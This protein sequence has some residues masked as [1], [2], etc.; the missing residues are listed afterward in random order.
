MPKVFETLVADNYDAAVVIQD[1]PPPHI[2]DDPSYYRNDGRS[3]IRACNA[4]DIPGA[5]CS[6]L[7]E[8]IDPESREMLIS[9]NITPLQGLDSGLKALA[10]AC[11]YGARR[12]Q[13]LE[14]LKQG[15]HRLQ[16]TDKGSDS[17]IVDEWQGKQ[18]LQQH[19]IVI[20]GGHFVAESGSLDLPE[21]ATYPVVVKAVSPGLA[22]KSEL[23]LVK[24]GIQS[25]EQVLAAIEEI[26]QRS[27]TPLEGFLVEPM[28]T[29]VLAELMVGINT[30]VQFGQL[31]VIASGG[32]LVELLRDSATLLLPTSETQ[33]REALESLQ[34]F[35][36][37]RGFRGKPAADIDLVIETIMKLAGFA[38]TNQGRLIEMDI[39]P[40]MITPTGCFAADV[41]IRE[42][43]A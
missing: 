14:N 21:D 7:P 35:P 17:K 10:H 31:L 23:G 4:F 18:R 6:D 43:Q 27:E 32:T 3:F 25:R 30:D 39:N 41:M 12:D 1:Y 16:S 36:L 40:L 8:N 24:T 22:H 33:V 37:L 11:H 26:R 15:F 34:M 5:V 13:R 29:E 28:V 38:E 9:G 19:G 20:P 2:H 42:A